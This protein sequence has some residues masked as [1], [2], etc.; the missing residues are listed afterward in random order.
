MIKL[1]TVAAFLVQHDAGGG[2]LIGNASTLGTGVDD[3]TGTANTRQHGV[4][5]ARE[6]QALEGEPVRAGIV[7]EIIARQDFLTTQ[8]ASP[9]G[10]G[11]EQD[12]V[13]V[14]AF[15]MVFKTKGVF[16]RFLNIQRPDVFEEL[17]GHFRN[18]SGR[19]EERR[20]QA[21][22]G[23]RVRGIVADVILRVDNERGQFHDVLI[24]DEGVF[25]RLL[26]DQCAGHQHAA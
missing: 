8:T 1:R 10:H 12:L 3:A 7:G 11:L 25:G 20:L 26:G 5:T 13:V 6:T 15:R 23:K 18:G 22:A 16:H 14:A 17:G 2:T 21:G 4:R 9:N 24:V 19:I